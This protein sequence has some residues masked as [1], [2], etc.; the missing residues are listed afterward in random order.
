MTSQTSHD[1]TL[2]DLGWSAFFMGQLTLEEFETLR[3]LRLIAV[4][5]DRATG[6]GP[7]GPITMTFPPTLP[8]GDTAVGDW[9]MVDP[10]ARRI[11]RVLGRQS[12]IARK[13]AGT[14]NR[15]QLMAAN[16]DTLFL[17]TSCNADFNPARLERYL[18]LAL[19]AGV[20]PVVVLTKA[21][22]ADDPQDFVARAA[23]VSPRIA[24]VVALDATDAAALAPLAPWLGRG[25]TIAFLGSS[26][27]GKSTLVTGLTGDGIA[28]QPVR[29]DDAKGRHTTTS[30][31]LR[32]TVGGAMVI[33]MPGMRE[34]AL[35]DA[36]TGIDELFDDIL[37]LARRCRFRDCAH[38]AEP[39]CAV[40]AAVD[41]GDLDPARLG[42]WR[43][44]RREDALN[45][46]ARHERRS[47]ERTFG[48]VVKE[49]IDLKRK[50]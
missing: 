46:E 1:L 42:R 18:A 12:V 40:Q 45:S 17:V 39:G 48:R 32:R 29:E 6:L 33:D 31:T 3:P 37:D 22:L 34:I 8:A 28:T 23:A 35:Q 5:R 21:D 11:A 41:G 26:G 24:D 9:V 25:Q 20:T 43:K 15:Q 47:R 2:A 27:V 30:R 19:D 36:S 13:A 10:A 7:D 14:D 38:E 44:L 16:V 50:G 49:A 4:E